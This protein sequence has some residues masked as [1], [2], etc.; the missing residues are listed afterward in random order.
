VRELEKPLGQIAME[1]AKER[2]RKGR[3][4]LRKIGSEP[5]GAGSFGESQEESPEGQT[6]LARAEKR[7]RGGGLLWMES[8]GEFRGVGR[9]IGS[10]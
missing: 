5:G 3:R 10:Q 6:S 4:L 8:K 7:A 2:V 1:E 9:S